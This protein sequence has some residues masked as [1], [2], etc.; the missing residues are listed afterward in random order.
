MKDFERLYNNLNKLDLNDVFLQIWKDSKVQ[1]YIIDLNT[2]GEST[3]QLYELGEDSTGRSLGNYSPVTIDYKLFGSGDSRIDHITL[4]D[5]GEF[6]ESFKV[7]PMKTG[8]K[9]TANP[10]K[11]D[12][13]LFQ[14]YGADIV[15]LNEDNVE[16]L[17]AFVEDDFNKELE[18]R[19]LG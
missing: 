14:V 13:N 11:D 8:F 17:L 18:K 9:M 15:G 2:E 10:N 6:Y 19:I 7:L 5:T 16:L 1:K 12:T 4:K 3:S